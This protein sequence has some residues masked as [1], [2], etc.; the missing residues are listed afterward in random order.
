M[1]RT[2]RKGNERAWFTRYQTL[3]ESEEADSSEAPPRRGGASGD[4]R[5]VPRQ[6]PLN[7]SIQKQSLLLH[8]RIHGENRML[9]F[10]QII[11]EFFRSGSYA[12]IGYFVE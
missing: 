6:D 7:S 11:Q 10:L 1:F 8:Q 5:N 9:N 12:F 3:C 4:A 2:A